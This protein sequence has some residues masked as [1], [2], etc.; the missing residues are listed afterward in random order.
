MSA[1]SDKIARDTSSTFERLETKFTWRSN[2]YACS[3]TY[4]T[5]GIEVEDLGGYFDEAAIT[6]S[7]NTSE[8][9]GERPDEGDLV[10][11]EGK[12][13]VVDKEPIVIAGTPLLI[14]QLTEPDGNDAVSSDY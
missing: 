4:G 12:S 9:T 11:V 14:F 10:E 5:S 1:F 6:I 8:M 2:N 3:I 13:W 7:T